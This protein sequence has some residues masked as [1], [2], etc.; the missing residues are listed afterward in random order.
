MELKLEQKLI[1][2]EPK[3]CG[4]AH[5]C[6]KM[7]DSVAWLKIPMDHKKT[8]VPGHQSARHSTGLTRRM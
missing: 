8:V 1:T 4:L 5:F 2:I 7:T 3:F 6:A